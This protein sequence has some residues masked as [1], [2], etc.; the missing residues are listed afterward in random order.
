[1]LERLKRLGRNT[2]K[3]MPEPASQSDPAATGTPRE[4][5]LDTI[6]QTMVI[7]PSMMAEAREAGTQ[8]ADAQ[9]TAVVEP[10]RKSRSK[11]R[12]SPAAQPDAGNRSRRRCTGRDCDRPRRYSRY[13][14]CS[15]MARS[16]IP[17]C[18]DC[19]AEPSSSGEP[20]GM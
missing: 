19:E 12:G 13:S 5:G 2:P 10:A 15:M 3:T 9:K 4:D 1:M 6:M 18:T 17:R 8:V 11:R 20:R 14:L 7:D 16:R